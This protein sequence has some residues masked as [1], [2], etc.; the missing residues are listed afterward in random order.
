MKA[1][2][3]KFLSKF[4]NANTFFL[5]GLIVLTIMTGYTYGKHDQALYIPLVNKILNPDLFTRDAFEHFFNNESANFLKLL[6]PLFRTVGVEIGFFILYYIGFFVLV[7]ASYLIGKEIFKNRNAGYVFALVVLASRMPSLTPETFFATR[8]LILPL[9]LIAVYFFIKSNYK[10]SYF[11]VGI[12]ANF[13]QIS[14]IPLIII[15]ALVH[16][17]LIK[18]IGIKKTIVCVFLFLLGF[19]PTIIQILSGTGTKIILTADVKWYKFQRILTNGN[20]S[21][22]YPEGTSSTTAFL[23]SLL[24]SFAI[25]LL[26]RKYRSLLDSKYKEGYDKLSLMLLFTI[27]FLFVVAVIYRVYPSVI[28]VQLQLI[29]ASSYLTIFSALG[30]GALLYLLFINNKIHKLQ[31]VVTFMIFYLGSV[32]ESVVFLVLAILLKRFVPKFVYYI[33]IFIGLII[34]SQVF[35]VNRGLKLPEGQFSLYIKDEDFVNLQLWMKDNTPESSLF[36]APTYINDIASGNIRVISERNILFTP[37]ELWMNII[38]Y[39][40]YKELV[41]LLDDLSNG[42]MTESINEVDGGKLFYD[43]LTKSYKDLTSDDVLRF[44]QKYGI[45]YF[46]VESEFSYDFDEVYSNNGYRAYKL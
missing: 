31:G 9:L 6:A 5:L 32:F 46:I 13:H 23:L 45:D 8:E 17:V 41:S 27:I 33:F 26:L 21:I 42:K 11:L 10:L 24:G 43:V 44:K 12:L 40:H 16:L 19:A 37:S 2:I 14:A 22:F 20:Y 34:F 38:D 25:F 36:L 28:L 15:L 35:L 1:V 7:L 29:R 39:K 18:S 3:V 30:L 4:N